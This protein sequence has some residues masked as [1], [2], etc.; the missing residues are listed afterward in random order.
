MNIEQTFKHMIGGLLFFQLL[1]SYKA[2]VT[3]YDFVASF[4]EYILYIISILF[5][6]HAITVYI[7]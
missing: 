2:G 3:K 4:I 7:K 6:C 5:S 1:N